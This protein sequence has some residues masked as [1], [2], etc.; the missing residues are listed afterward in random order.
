MS[1]AP[2]NCRKK[3]TNQ[4]GVWCKQ[5]H[6]LTSTSTSSS[7]KQEDMRGHTRW[8]IYW[9]PIPRRKSTTTK[10]A[11][12]NGKK[13]KMKILLLSHVC[14]YLLKSFSGKLGQNIHKYTQHNILPI[15]QKQII[16][17]IIIII[18]IIFIIIIIIKTM[19]KM[20]IISQL[21]IA[22]AN[23][24][25]VR[26]LWR[27]TKIARRPWTESKKQKQKQL[28]VCVTSNLHCTD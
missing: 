18:I 20:I 3:I 23:P 11:T 17:L 28:D 7:V 24:D 25:W 13:S 16:I 1:T 10:V 19:N 26:Y 4:F 2:R 27:Q 8:R 21:V 12:S 6:S 5:V 9:K 14:Q 22:F 15:K